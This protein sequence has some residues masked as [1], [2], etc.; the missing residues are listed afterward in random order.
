MESTCGAYVLIPVR[1][2]NIAL[3]F[4]SNRQARRWP[5]YNSY[6]LE[7]VFAYPRRNRK[8][9]VMN[10]LHTVEFEFGFTPYTL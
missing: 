8:K 1:I 9:V 7:S 4:S 10:Y 2:Q 3:F 6:T 5:C